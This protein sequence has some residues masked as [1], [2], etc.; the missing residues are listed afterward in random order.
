[1]KLLN[2][3]LKLSIAGQVL[4]LTGGGIEEGKESEGEKVQGLAEVEEDHSAEVEEE[5]SSESEYDSS[6]DSDSDIKSSKTRLKKP[7]KVSKVV[8]E[9]LEVTSRINKFAFYFL[10]PPSQRTGDERRRLNSRG[11]RRSP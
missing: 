1:M 8:K 2:S 5:H 10:A 6:D 7:E 3:S 11:K 9:E 4:E